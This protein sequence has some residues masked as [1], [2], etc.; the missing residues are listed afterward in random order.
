MKVI[1]KSRLY[2]ALSVLRFILLRVYYP[3]RMEATGVS[4]IGR[5]CGIYIFPGGRLACGDRMI[6]DDHV[7]LY[8]KGNI[9][10]GNSFNI[11]QY[12]RIVAHEKIE[13][14]DNVV[15]GQFVTI[16]D[17]DH[18]HEFQG[19]DL[20]FS[21]YRTQPVKIGSNVW[22]ADKCFVFRNDGCRK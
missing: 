7:M 6:L 20:T 5:K 17:H 3:K 16:L 18:N 2:K 21:G 15:L 4:M 19:E 10:I 9:S 14:G 22:I 8:A 12:S 13:I 11:N 1:Y